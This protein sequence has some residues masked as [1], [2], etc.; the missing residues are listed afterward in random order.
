MSPRTFEVAKY[1]DDRLHHTH[2]GTWCVPL[3]IERI[4]SLRPTKLR[5]RVPLGNGATN[6]LGVDALPE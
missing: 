6:E 2:R 4:E 1:P 3:P 5:F